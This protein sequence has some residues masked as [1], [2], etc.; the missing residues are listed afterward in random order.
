MNIVL[1]TAINQRSKILLHLN[2]FPLKFLESFHYAIFKL[3][4]KLHMQEKKKVWIK[5]IVLGLGE[6]FGGGST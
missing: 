6:K 1:L 4:V 5:I 3:E 2:G